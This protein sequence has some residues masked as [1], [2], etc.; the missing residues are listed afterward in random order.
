MPLGLFGTRIRDDEISEDRVVVGESVAIE[1]YL[2]WQF[3]QWWYG[4]DGQ[5]IDIL[6]NEQEV[7]RVGVGGGGYFKGIH[8]FTSPG[9]FIIKARYRGDGTFSSAESSPFDVTV[10]TKEQKEEEERNFYL[11]VGGVGAAGLVGVG[12]LAYWYERRQRM[13]M[14]MMARR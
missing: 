6:V 5:Y 7:A 9:S 13:E 12:A 14:L 1:G 8:R 10:I 2:E 11:L 3:L 4:L